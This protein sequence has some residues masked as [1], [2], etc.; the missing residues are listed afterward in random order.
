MTSLIVLL[1]VCVYLFP[2]SIQ[3]YSGF[4]SNTF[5]IKKLIW[6]M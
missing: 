3:P 4:R 2:K 5:V 1:C 6:K